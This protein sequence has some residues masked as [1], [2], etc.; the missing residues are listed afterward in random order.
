VVRSIREYVATI[1]PA[2]IVTGDI[3]APRAVNEASIDVAV[4]RKPVNPG[5]LREAMEAALK[6]TPV[7]G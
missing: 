5:R 1:V 2:V 7:Q 4:L 6:T 3:S